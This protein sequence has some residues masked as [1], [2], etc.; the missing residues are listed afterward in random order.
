MKQWQLIEQ[1]L[2]DS[3]EITEHVI[4]EYSDVRIALRDAIVT[5]EEMAPQEGN[6]LNYYVRP[7]P[8]TSIIPGEPKSQHSEP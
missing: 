6:Y 8:V 3:T 4:S 1:R 7:K 5:S 2:E